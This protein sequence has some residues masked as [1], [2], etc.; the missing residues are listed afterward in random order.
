VTFIS[1]L[2]QTI[3]IS[4]LVLLTLGTSSSKIFKKGFTPFL[5]TRSFFFI[6][7]VAVKKAFFYLTSP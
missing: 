3:V 5:A 1:Y 4:N 7:P 6:N 2:F